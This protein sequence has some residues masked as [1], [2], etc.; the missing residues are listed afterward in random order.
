MKVQQLFLS[1]LVVFSI[2]S[3]NSC[4]IFSDVAN[5][6][7][8]QTED[9]LH[10]KFT[11]DS[12]SLYTITS[13]ELRSRGA[14]ENL[15]S[16]IGEWGDNLLA[17]NQTLI[18]GATFYFDADIPSGEWSQCRLSIDNGNGSVILIGEDSELSITHW[19]SNDRTVGVVLSYDQYS[20]NIYVSGWSEWAGIE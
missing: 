14:V 7:N 5:P 15:D 6:E 10:V 16:P 11:N 8:T 1:A 17:E 9:L 19:G 13:I 12:L 20:D 3:L 2:I 18:P 4:D